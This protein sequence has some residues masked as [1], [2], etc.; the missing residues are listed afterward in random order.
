MKKDD[1]IKQHYIPISFQKRW[2]MKSANNIFHYSATKNKISCK[3]TGIKSTF[4][5]EYLYKYCDYIS[6]ESYFHDVETKSEPIF[7][8]ILNDDIIDGDEYLY[9]LRFISLGKSRNP[10]FIESGVLG[11]SLEDII[12]FYK[13][14]YSVSNQVDYK[15]ASFLFTLNIG[16]DVLLDKIEKWK[17]PACFVVRMDNDMLLCTDNVFSSFL[18]DFGFSIIPLSPSVALLFID[19]IYGAADILKK[20]HRLN[21]MNFALLTNLL[22]MRASNS[23]IFNKREENHNDLI[24]NHSRWMESKCKSDFSCNILFGILNNGKSFGNINIKSI[25]IS[26]RPCH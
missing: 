6:Y 13:R 18:S 17:M 12:D 10:Y 7:S 8:K 16:E 1:S 25:S 5:I 4:Q 22:N 26:D 21:E 3:Q 9:I 23:A 11:Y 24:L 20:I 15:K 14:F 19:N 2:Y